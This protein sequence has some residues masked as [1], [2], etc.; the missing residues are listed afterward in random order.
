IFGR[1]LSVPVQIEHELLLT[2]LDECHLAQQALGLSFI[3][4]DS[5]SALST[6]IGDPWDT[7]ID[8][9][10]DEADLGS[11]IHRRNEEKRISSRIDDEDE[12]EGSG[13]GHGPNF[14]IDH[15]LPA[16]VA[17]TPTTTTTTTERSPSEYFDKDP[18]EDVDEEDDDY[19]DEDDED[20]EEYDDSEDGIDEEEEEEDNTRVFVPPPPETPVQTTSRSVEPDIQEESGEDGDDEEEDDDYDSFEPVDITEEEVFPDLGVRHKSSEEDDMDKNLVPVDPAREVPSVE[21][22]PP[23]NMPDGKELGNDVYIYGTPKDDTTTSFFSQPAIVGGAVV[24]LLFAIL[25]VMFIVYRMRKK[26]E[27][28]YILDEKRSPTSNSYSKSS[29]EFYA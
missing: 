18:K 21:S 19:Y 8:F 16:S 25:V 26:D 28:S 2:V 17:T 13:S 12:G 22:Q 11:G 15:E 23:G 14:H 9:L 7:D 20:D 4:Q 5:S 24:G 10:D 1:A 3:S 27:G 29:R 6:I